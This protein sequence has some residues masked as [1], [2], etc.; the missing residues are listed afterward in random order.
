MKRVY[1]FL[2]AL[3][4]VAFSARAQYNNNTPQNGY[5][6]FTTVPNGMF[7]GAYVFTFEFWV[8]TTETGSNN[9]YWQRPCLFGNAT[10]GDNSGDFAI[11]TNNGY[12]GMWEGISN[13]NTDQYFVSTFA[14]IND[15]QWHHIAAVNNGQSIFLYVDGR[16]VGSLVSGK[17]LRTGKAPLTF[18]AASFD[19]NLNGSLP[20]NINFPSQASFGEVRLSN[21]VRYIGNFVPERSYSADANT[22][23]LYHFGNQG[24]QQNNFGNQDNGYHPPYE[25]RGDAYIPK[26][27]LYLRDTVLTGRLTVG[28][29]NPGLNDEQVVRFAEGNSPNFNF[30][31]LEDVVGFQIGVD[32]FEP[33]FISATSGLNTPFPKTVLKR[34]TSVGTP[35]AMYEYENRANIRNAAGVLEV[36]TQLVY[37]IGLPGSMDDKVYSLSDNKFSPKFDEKV[38]AMV[39]DKPALADKIKSKNK[40]YFYAAFTTDEHRLRV[41]WNIINEYNTPN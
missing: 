16:S 38:S 20:G 25:Y 10:Y 40:D 3:I 36:K 30:Y 7:N 31:R 34:L 13:R 14:R 26:A 19:Y 1:V 41:W 23:Q 2:T 12:I 18:G 39:Q 21:S 28:R 35:M 8:K 15:N 22:M 11:T 37:L 27:T 17:P 29:R 32:Y 33:K 4:L 9:I 6:Q 5:A 24:N